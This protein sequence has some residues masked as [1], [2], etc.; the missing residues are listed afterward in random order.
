MMVSACLIGARTAYDGRDRLSMPLAAALS[1]MKV[2][3]FCPE[4]L[5]GLPTPRAPSEIRSP[6]GRDPDCRLRVLS[7][8]GDDVTEAF[9]RGAR[10]SVHLATRLGCSVAVMK[11]RSPS[12]S[13]GGLY[14][15]TFTGRVIEGKGLAARA[16]EDEGV[17]VMT[18]AKFLETVELRDDECEGR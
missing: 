11:P 13:P 3:A 1:G 17:R 14:D 6:A 9:A 18:P 10:E 5:G 12:C 8:D 4:Q 16:L 2:V 7:E 15:G